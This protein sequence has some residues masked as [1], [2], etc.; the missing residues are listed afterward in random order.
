MAQSAER[1][2][3][4]FRTNGRIN[5]GLIQYDFFSLLTSAMK[6]RSISLLFLLL[7]INVWSENDRFFCHVLL[8]EM[9]RKLGQTFPISLNP[10]AFEA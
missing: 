2:T 10:K 5:F 4:N 6:V 8:T 1:K 9:L 7:K 3:L